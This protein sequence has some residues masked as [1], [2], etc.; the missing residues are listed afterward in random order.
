MTNLVY[1]ERK[2]EESIVTTF[3]RSGFGS[4]VRG[5]WRS[6]LEC[7]FLVLFVQTCLF[8]TVF[9]LRSMVNGEHLRREG[10][11][12]IK[13]FLWNVFALKSIESA[14]STKKKTIILTFIND[15]KLSH[16]NETLRLHRTTQI[17][18]ISIAHVKF[19]KQIINI[20]K[21]YMNNVEKPHPYLY[22]L[23]SK[24]RAQNHGK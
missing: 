8:S 5:V 10:P 23:H 12:T 9:G 18:C 16:R 15:S 19:E 11:K 13:I 14:P 2:R 17:S 22:Y 7:L 3:H 1:S 21:E 20:I 6:V 24:Q 4:S